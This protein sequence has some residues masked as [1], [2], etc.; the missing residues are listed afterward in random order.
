MFLCHDK[1]L[2]NISNSIGSL[3]EGTTCHLTAGNFDDAEMLSE[4]LRVEKNKE[5]APGL[6]SDDESDD[7]FMGDLFT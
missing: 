5:T 6:Y 1:K 3:C 2:V 4:H 7:N